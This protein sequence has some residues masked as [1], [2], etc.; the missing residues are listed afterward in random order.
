VNSITALAEL[1]GQIVT[2]ADPATATTVTP[3]VVAGGTADNVVPARTRLSVDVRVEQAG[4]DA[5]LDAA[6][7]G[8]TTTVPGA[9]IEILGGLNRPPMPIGSAG[10]LFD[11][12]Q[13]AAAAIGIGPLQGVAV[14]GGSDGNFTAARGVPTLDGMGAVGG[15]AH[16]D[17]EWIDVEA[18]RERAALLA[19]LLPL[20]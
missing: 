13:E 14:G 4:E 16:A 1:V 8:L 5:R 7:A 11:L 18:M 9:T 17:H 20:I 2:F 12:A 6:F 19:A 10:R 3:T 15:G